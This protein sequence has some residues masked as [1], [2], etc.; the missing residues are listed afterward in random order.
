[1]QKENVKSGFDMTLFFLQERHHQIRLIWERQPNKE[2]HFIR[3]ADYCILIKY[4]RQRQTFFFRKMC[5]CESFAI[6]P[7][8]CIMKVNRV[9]LDIKQLNDF[10]TLDRLF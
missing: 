2:N 8:M 3:Q 9:N 1:M 5:A 6:K 4:H 7:G 10:W